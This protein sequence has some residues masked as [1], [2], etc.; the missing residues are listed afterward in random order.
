MA[1]RNPYSTV[2]FGTCI[3]VAGLGHSHC[4][5]APEYAALVAAGYRHL[6][7]SHYRA[8]DPARSY[9]LTNLSGV[10]SGDVTADIIGGPNAEHFDFTGGAVGH[11]NAYGSEFVSG[12]ASTGY[13]GPWNSFADEAL[14]ELLYPNGG[15][16]VWNHPALGGTISEFFKSYLDYDDRVLGLEVYNHLAEWYFSGEGWALG[17][18]HKMMVTGRRCFG[19]FTLDHWYN[20]PGHPDAAGVNRLLVP[21]AYSGQTRTEREQALMEAYREGRFYGCVDF[22]SPTLVDF[23]ADATEVTVEFDASCDITFVWARKNDPSARTSAITTG[24][25]A[26]FA[27]SGD[28]VYVRAVGQTSATSISM[29]QA[30]M[31][32]DV[33]DLTGGQS[34]RRRRRQNFGG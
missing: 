8:S 6:A 34:A 1:I 20:V 16:I 25:T 27:L 14:A 23:T 18:W 22:D 31:F 7:I 30:V 5:D 2:N 32:L 3:E 19:F 4:A 9:P 33:A 21:A 12:T 17:Q 24:T 26:T 29:T 11:Y 15:G 13:G 10:S 28:E